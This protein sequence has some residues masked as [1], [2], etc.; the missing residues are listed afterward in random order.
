[1]AL[2]KLPKTVSSFLVPR[3][4]FKLKNLNACFT[5]NSENVHSDP[6]LIIR[7]SIVPLKICEYNDCAFLNRFL[8]RLVN[9]FEAQI[10]IKSVND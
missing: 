9:R 5:G 7:P 8:R 6:K 10:H 1:M 4:C 3:F 2:S